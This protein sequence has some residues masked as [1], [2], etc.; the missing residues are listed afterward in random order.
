MCPTCF[1]PRER[2]VMGSPEKLL[3]VA[4]SVECSL[5]GVSLRLEKLTGQETEV[6]ELF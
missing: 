2:A 4:R 5:T 3:S 6:R 1:R